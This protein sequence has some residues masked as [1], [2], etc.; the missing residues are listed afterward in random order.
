MELMRYKRYIPSTCSSDT[1]EIEDGDAQ[2]LIKIRNGIKF[3]N[4]LAFGQKRQTAIKYR[5]RIIRT[6]CP[7]RRKAFS[8]SRC[9]VRFYIEA[10]HIAFHLSSV[11]LGSGLVNL[12]TALK[13]SETIEYPFGEDNCCFLRRSFGR[14]SSFKLIQ[15]KCGVTVWS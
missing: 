12:H 11:L 15:G 7:A 6:M 1:I 14:L 2:N 13:K 4:L 3:N 9:C 8:P 10:V 5:W